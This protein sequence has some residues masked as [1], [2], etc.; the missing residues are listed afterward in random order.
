[1]RD[2]TKIRRGRNENRAREPSADQRLDFL[3]RAAQADA[4]RRDDDRV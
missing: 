3:G 2:Q 4:P 1:M